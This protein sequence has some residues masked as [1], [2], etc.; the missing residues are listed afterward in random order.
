LI[1]SEEE[2]FVFFNRSAN[3]S[4]KLVAL[5]EIF[6]RRE[7]IAA[8]EF[9]VSNELKHSSVEIIRARLCNCVECSA[10]V[11]AILGGQGTGLNLEFLKSIGEWQRQSSV[12]GDIVVHR[13]IQGHRVAGVE[14]SRN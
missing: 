3:A 2:Q 4:A 13:A 9:V 7:K 8:V 11:E 5:Q 6:G 14:T 10:R 1:A 12:G